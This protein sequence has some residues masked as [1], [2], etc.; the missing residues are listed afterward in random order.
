MEQEPSS[1]NDALAQIQFAR[2]Q[3]S[4]TGAADVEK[5]QLDA[6]ERQVMSGK[7]SAQEAM[8]KVRRM[9]EGRQDY[10]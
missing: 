3:L 2:A 7:I 5:G 4:A 6:L 8:D 10:H 9:L 1:I